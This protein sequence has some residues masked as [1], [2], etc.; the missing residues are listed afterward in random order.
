MPTLIRKARCAACNKKY[1][2]TRDWQRFCS[3]KCRMQAK[4]DGY[5]PAVAIERLVKRI[6]ARWVD[7]I[8]DREI[9]KAKSKLKAELL[10]EL[11]TP[12]YARD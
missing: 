12:D 7:T 10:K 11:T 2:K 3:E 1:E 4:K 8:I 9:Q 6:V 5:L